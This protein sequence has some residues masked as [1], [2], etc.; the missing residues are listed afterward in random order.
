MSKAINRDEIVSD[1]MRRVGIKKDEQI[2]D[3]YFRS[4][5]KIKYDDIYSGE[6][7]DKGKKVIDK[8]KKRK[9]MAEVAK[10]IDKKPRE[11]VKTVAEELNISEGAVRKI[12]TCDEFKSMINKVL[13]VSEVVQ[14]FANDFRG[15]PMDRERLME[16]YTK[17]MG[18]DKQVVEVN[19]NKTPELEAMERIL[20]GESVIEATQNSEGVFEVE[21]EGVEDGE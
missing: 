7:N 21:T 11:I 10:N 19:F 18:F 20:G 16:I 14:G 9:V 6:V 3:K 1:T 13:P 17:W 5:P 4:L 12:I 2:R 15:K 8:I